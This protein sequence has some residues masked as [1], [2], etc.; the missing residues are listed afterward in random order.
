M[1]FY[2]AI[3]LICLLSFYLSY[4]LGPGKQRIAI[5]LSTLLI[6]IIFSGT[7]LG[8]G[9]FDYFVYQDV[10]NIIPMLDKFTSAPIPGTFGMEQGYLLLNSAAKTFGLSFHGFT[11]LMSAVF[12]IGFYAA[13]KPYFANFSFVL[14]VFLYKLLFYNTFISMR[15]PIAIIIFF[16]ALKFL[17]DKKPVKYL[18]LI[19]LGGLFHMSILFLAPLYLLNFFKFTRNKFIVINTTFAIIFMI[20]YFQIANINP[21]SILSYIFSGSPIFLEKVIRYFNS[22]S[23]TVNILN[24][25]EYFAL[26]A[27]VLA[28]FNKIDF[29]T[30]RNSTIGYLLLATGAILTIFYNFEIIVR[31][32]DFFII[33]YAYIIILLLKAIDNNKTK[34]ALM[35]CTIGICLLGYLRYPLTFDNENL[36]PYSSYLLNETSRTKGYE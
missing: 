1:I 7:R 24:V 4:R 28:Y 2:I 33:F 6:L 17:I 15:Q 31:M 35:V 27:L 30:R 19:A 14:I 10:Y 32:K 25:V 21:I 12:Y 20:S 9:G 11:L 5:E 26:S 36:I 34:I 23:A 29:S 22:P 18:T 8:I 16:F 3:F 13:L